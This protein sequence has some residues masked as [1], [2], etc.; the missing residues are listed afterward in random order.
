[1]KNTPQYKQLKEAMAL[2]R[3]MKIPDHLQEKALEHLLQGTSAESPTTAADSGVDSSVHKGAATT[4]DLRNFISKHNPKSAVAEI[5]ALLSWAKK[6]EKKEIANE[7]DIL[8]LYRRANIRP[9]KNIAQSVRDLASKKYNRLE[10]VKGK[11]GYVQLSQAGED[12]VLYD[13]SKPTK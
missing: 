10:A 11:A 7:H 3:E 12:F 4:Q 6:Y 5:P 8:E 1:M 9:P 13:L 2:I